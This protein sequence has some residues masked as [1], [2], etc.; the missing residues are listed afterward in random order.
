MYLRKERKNIEGISEGKTKINFFLVDLTDNKLFKMII[1]TMCLD[2]YTYICMYI[3]T[4]T[5]L[6]ISETDKWYKEQEGR[7]RIMLL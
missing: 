7:I 5:Y 4:Y 1:S 3:F 6:Y 2:V